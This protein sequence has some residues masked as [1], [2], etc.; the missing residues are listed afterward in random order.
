MLLLF[1]SKMRVEPFGVG[2]VLHVTNRGVRGAGIV[3]DEDDRARFERS[4]YYLNDT[5]TDPYWHR[6]VADMSPFSRPEDWPERDPLVRILA[7]TLLSNHFHLLLQETREGGVAKFMQRLGGSLSSCFNA[8][9][10]ERGSLFQGSYHARLVSKDEHRQYLVF[11]ILIKNVLEMYPGGLPAAY[12]NFDRA[13][14]WAMRYR[15]SSLPTFVSRN[16]SPIIDDPEDLISGF[17]DTEKMY[18]KEALELLDFYIQSRGEEFSD[19][20]LEAW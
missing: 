20:M 1:V 15:Y 11:Y 9:Y 17:A 16:Q 14:E 19:L 8:K 5:H 10:R 12:A 13:W 18:K 7:W 4:L 3:R 2:S 6:A